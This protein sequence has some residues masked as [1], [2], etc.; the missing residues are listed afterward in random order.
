[1]RRGLAAAAAAAALAACAGGDKPFV[2]SGDYPLPPNPRDY[3]EPGDCRGGSRLAGLDL[4]EP[5]YPR[6]AF[7]RGQQ[8]WVALRLDVTP[9]GVTENVEVVASEPGGAFDRAARRTV[10]SWTFEPPGEP[11]V[12]RCVV[13]LDYRLGEGRIGF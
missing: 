9:A 12:T 13:V 6:R 2:P 3:V 10:R 4:A 7:R 5:E 8:G 1:M 11:G